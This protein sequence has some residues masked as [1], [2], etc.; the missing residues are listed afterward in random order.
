MATIKKHILKS[1]KTVYRANVYLGIDPSSGKAKYTN[2]SAYSQRDAQAKIDKI[3]LDRYDKK[4]ILT[5][6]MTFKQVF[7][8]WFKGYKSNVKPT[9]IE[10]VTSKFTNT[11][12]P[13]LAYYKLKNITPGICQSMLQTLI[14]EKQKDRAGLTTDKYRFSY[15]TVKE[16]RMY[17]NN[18]FKYAIKMGYVSKNPMEYVD[19][20][21]RKESFLYEYN[22]GSSITKRKYWNKDE[23]KQFLEIAKDE[24][25]LQDYAMFRLILFTGMRKG[26]LHG[27]LRKDFNI[28]NNEITINKTLSSIDS[29]Y[30]LQTP[31]TASSNRIINIDP[32]TA[33]IVIKHLD[34]I[35]KELLALGKRNLISPN[36]PIFTNADGNF[37][38]LSH[39]NNIM[40]YNFYKH[41]PDFYK[42]TIH[43][44]RHTHASLMFESGASLKDVQAKL[45]HSD[46]QTTMN[47]YT[48]VTD[49]KAKKTQNNFASFMDF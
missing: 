27:L 39:L 8:S 26:E 47:I 13:Y 22:A 31:K 15:R 35:N 33:K 21:K 12:L 49:T 17:T 40:D 44:M 42:I 14:D 38:T 7:E 1:G 41:H 19:V 34:N 30:V 25:N 24:F 9:T 23:V 3:S 4:T 37:I 45:G 29:K 5:N 32:V 20:P 11:V 48:H 46:I 2:I 18:V 16:I 36:L 43:Q 6:N 28:Q 10:T